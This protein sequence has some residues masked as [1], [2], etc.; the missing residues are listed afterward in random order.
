MVSSTFSSSQVINTNNNRIVCDAP[1]KPTFYHVATIINGKIS[2]DDNICVKKPIKIKFKNWDE[3]CN[4][5][6]KCDAKNIQGI[7]CFSKNCLDNTLIH[8]IPATIKI[9]NKDYQQ[10]FLARGNEPSIKFRYLQ[11]RMDRSLTGMLYYLYPSMSN[12][13]DD[14]ENTIYELARDIYKSYVQRFIKKRYVTVPREEFNVIRTCHSWHLAAR[15]ENRISLVKVIEV[16]NTQSPTNINHMIRRY[17]SEQ[18]RK[19][20]AGTTRPRKESFHST[21]NSPL[22]DYEYKI[23]VKSPPSLTL[24]KSQS[25]PHK[26]LKTMNKIDKSNMIPKFKRILQR[27]PV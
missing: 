11:V 14:Y 17:K 2:L 20:E 7:I 4:Y 13:F 6:R 10:L 1:E 18:L 3:L 23:D 12:I 25:F 22:M 5:S 24:A 8:K 27:K 19:K 26:I 21:K 15:D 9:L 16:L